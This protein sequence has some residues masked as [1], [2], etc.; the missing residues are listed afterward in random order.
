MLTTLTTNFFCISEAIVFFS[1][2]TMHYTFVILYP[3]C[4]PV[5]RER[6]VCVTSAC[7]VARNKNP[8]IITLVAVRFIKILSKDCYHPYYSCHFY[9]I[10]EQNHIAAPIKSS[11][12]LCCNV[13]ILFLQSWFPYFRLCL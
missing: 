1:S 7:H 13:F 4:P 5:G 8:V 9:T 3:A 6:L 11:M 10:S 2:L 12:N